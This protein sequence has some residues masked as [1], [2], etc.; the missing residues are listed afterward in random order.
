MQYAKDMP[1]IVG[2]VEGRDGLIPG[3]AVDLRQPLE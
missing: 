2:R 3:V 1:M